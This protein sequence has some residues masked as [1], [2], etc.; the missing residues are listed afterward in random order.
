M[1]TELGIIQPIA[2]FGR[3]YG[4][5]VYFSP[6]GKRILVGEEK[7]EDPSTDR[8]PHYKLYDGQGVLIADLGAVKWGYMT[9][10]G[11]VGVAVDSFPILCNCTFSPESWKLRFWSLDGKLIKEEKGSG[12]SFPRLAFNPARS[13]FVTLRGY[14]EEYLWSSDGQKIATLSLPNGEDIDQASFSPDGT[15]IALSART[16]TWLVDENGT[17]LRRLALLDDPHAS[18]EIFFHPQGKQLT[19]A[20]YDHSEVWTIDGQFLTTLEDVEILAYHPNGRYLIGRQGFENQQDGIFLFDIQHDFAPRLLATYDS[21]YGF[22]FDEGGKHLITLGC[23]NGQ[24]WESGFFCYGGSATLWDEDGNFI[25]ELK[26]LA[27]VMEAKFLPNRDRTITAGCDGIIEYSRIIP[28]S[29]CLSK[30]LRLQDENGHTI[31]ILHQEIENFW[32]SPDGSL[33]ITASQKYD[34]QAKLWK[35]LP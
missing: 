25:A 2:E 12:G 31:A 3:V 14:N 20:D 28:T 16:A 26:G 6:D 33:L 1:I 18:A 13:K 7:L 19:V 10:T 15:R 8:Y 29:Q 34:G 11:V 32:I 35:L 5:G 22:H 24:W 23:T 21:L 9:S 30:S 4:P 27:E 17:V